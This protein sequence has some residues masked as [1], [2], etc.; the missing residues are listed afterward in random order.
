MCC[1]RPRNIIIIHRA[2][3]RRPATCR[4]FR[5]T[6]P[7][8]NPPGRARS[9]AQQ[10]NHP[11]CNVAAKSHW[12]RANKCSSRPGPAPP[13]Q[14]G[15]G[16]AGRVVALTPRPSR[17]SAAPA[18]RPPRHGAFPPTGRRRARAAAAWTRHFCRRCS[19]FAAITPSAP[20][21]PSL[22]MCAAAAPWAG[23]LQRRPLHL[24]PSES[25]QLP[26]QYPAQYWHKVLCVAAVRCL[27]PSLAASTRDKRL[28]TRHSPSAH[29]S[30]PSR[31]KY[32][33]F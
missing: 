21:S 26:S 2:G 31:H 10:R 8:H 7:A 20:Y 12:R 11:R 9:P 32:A 27:F 13:R 16:A 30:P 23:L 4:G 1:C 29:S 17:S 14:E 19:Q 15:A 28:P 18:Q 33:P 25:H 22:S 5:H 6:S 24:A 3:R